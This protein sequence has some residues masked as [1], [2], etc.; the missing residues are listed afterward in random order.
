MSAA[1]QPTGALFDVLLLLHVVAAV[2]AL[3]TVVTSGAV[4]ARALSAAGRPP[5]PGVVRYF[6]PGV[7]WAG[8]SLHAVPL[9][10]AALVG[11]SGGAYRFGDGWVVAG[12][13]LW[14]A[15]AAAAEVVLW[16]AERRVQAGL[17]VVVATAPASGATVPDVRGAC[18]TLCASSGAVAALLV[19]AM[20]VMV[21]QP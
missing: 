20:V 1:A 9:L 13:A 4:A 14:V 11:L 12:L 7:N 15:A 16:P 10:G 21:A 19:A 3:A 2:V 17:V 8:R 18:R 6:A 5:A